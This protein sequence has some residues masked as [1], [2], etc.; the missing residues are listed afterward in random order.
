MK[1]PD[2]ETN[3]STISAFIRRFREQPP[4]P[5]SQRKSVGGK[6]NFWWLSPE[7]Q[8]KVLGDSNGQPHDDAQL[9]GWTEK[10]V[11]KG[12]IHTVVGAEPQS[13]RGQVDNW[14]DLSLSHIRD[15]HS[16]L[17]FSDVIPHNICGDS[18]DFDTQDLYVDDVTRLADQL[19]QKCESL[20]K[21]RD[22]SDVDNN[23]VLSLRSSLQSS[24]PPTAQ[25]SMQSS[26]QSSLQ[27]LSASQMSPSVLHGSVNTSTEWTT[28]SI[29]RQDYEHE[30]EWIPDRVTS[31]VLPLN[32]VDEVGGPKL[33]VSPQAD[34]HYSE[35]QAYHNK[36]GE[37]ARG[38]DGG[39]VVVGGDVDV[40]SDSKSD[41]GSNSSSD[42]MFI[43]PSTSCASSVHC[44]SGIASR[45]NEGLSPGF[46]AEVHKDALGRHSASEP[47]DGSPTV[48]R[49]S[50]GNQESLS[51]C[52]S[53]SEGSLQQSATAVASSKEQQVLLEQRGQQGADSARDDG[54]GSLQDRG[55]VAQGHGHGHGQGQGQHVSEEAVRRYLGGDPVLARL[56]AR[57]LDVRSAIQRIE[58]TA[59]MSF[60]V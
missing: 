25:S 4:A 12:P 9:G 18:L 56:W 45:R 34:L 37:A 58:V 21:Q 2:E 33:L 53:P 42:S 39:G 7:H 11:N 29:L 54:A 13:S 35:H 60:G 3:Q 44:Q 50:K 32:I 31:P 59:R 20:L 22:T 8:S 19:V 27:S 40:D 46:A 49:N 26:V 48:P 28:D 1:N 15:S 14:I 5:V 41:N 23:P 36:E 55:R 16:S 52:R 17:A 30:G 47:A 43:S 10:L 57:L 6:E 51:R 24:P 38:D